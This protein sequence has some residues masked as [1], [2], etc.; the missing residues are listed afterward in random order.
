[1]DDHELELARKNNILGLVLFLI[2]VA[3]VGATIAA[4]YIYLAVD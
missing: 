2:A 1:M 3:I 4:A